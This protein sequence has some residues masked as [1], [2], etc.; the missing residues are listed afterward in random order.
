MSI[1][2]KGTLNPIVPSNPAPI[3]PSTGGP[4]YGIDLFHEDD[5]QSWAEMLSNGYVFAILKASQGLSADPLFASRFAAAKA[6]GLIVGAYHFYSTSS[7]QASQAQFFSNLCQSVGYD[8]TDIPLCFDFENSSGNYSS[9]DGANCQAFLQ[10]LASI[11]GRIPLLYMSDSVP[12]ELGNPS[13]M[14]NYPWWIARYGA[15]P[16][17]PYIFW[18]Q[19]GSASIPGLGNP[20]DKNI[21]NGSVADLQQWI[22]KT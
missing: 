5:V 8:K 16:K 15:S 22:S 4:I 20:G 19:S 17:N 13:W 2:R 11:S 1:F 18:Q 9:S 12:G 14:S 3:A 21:F 7:D 6:A 10:E